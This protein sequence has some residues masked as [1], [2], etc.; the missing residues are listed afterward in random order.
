MKKLLFAALILVAIVAC[1]RDRIETPEGATNDTV[2]QNPP[3][4]ATMTDTAATTM[5]T[6]DV[7]TDTAMTTA[8]PNTDTALPADAA[9]APTQ[10]IA[11]GRDLYNARCAQC[12][13]ADGKKAAGPVSLATAA[14]QSKPDAELIRFVRENGAHRN[15]ATD[16][17][18]AA[19]AVAYIKALK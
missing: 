3:N 6:T 8:T 16:D 2:L 13:G 1:N 12:H 5:A 11:A 4:D 7:A 19:A 15:L 14:T 9:P 10:Q 17:A 18:Q